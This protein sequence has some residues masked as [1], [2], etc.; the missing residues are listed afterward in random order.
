MHTANIMFYNVAGLEELMTLEEK[1]KL[2]AAIGYSE[3]AVDP[4]LPKTVS[5]I[6]LLYLI[7]KFTNIP[8]RNLISSLT[9][10]N[11]TH[12]LGSFIHYFD[13]LNVCFHFSSLF[14]SLV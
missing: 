10:E 11:N 1:A 3:T 9:L 12:N 14:C 13:L 7:S 6:W 8:Y 5:K 4:T 2:Y